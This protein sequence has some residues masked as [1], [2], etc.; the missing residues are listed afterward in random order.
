MAPLIAA[1]SLALAGPAMAQVVGDEA[2]PIYAVDI[3]AFA[4]CD[5]DRVVR[6]QADPPR[7]SP[8]Q[9]YAMKRDRGGNVLLFDL[10]RPD[11]IE[12]TGLAE[13]VDGIVV[14]AEERSSSDDR[15]SDGVAE[16][17]VAPAFIEAM[18]I[19]VAV[20]G[21][22]PDTTLLLLCPGGQRAEKAARALHEAG[23]VN[24]TVVDGG[25]EGSHGADGIR[26][27]GWID[28]GLAMNRNPQIALLLGDDD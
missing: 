6:A 8:R 22:S 5:G 25:Y 3:A 16:P 28:A 17:V 14:Y 21:G 12:T 7:V 19:R 1:V 9:A 27:G 4:T 10:R 24:A 2:C 23:Y 26:R 20:L 18:K 15:G 13:D 11:E